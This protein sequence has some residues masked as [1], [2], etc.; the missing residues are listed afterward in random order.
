MPIIGGTR[1][2][3]GT[4]PKALSPEFLAKQG[5]KTMPAHGIHSFTVP[6]AV[7]GWAQMHKRYGKLPWK[8]LFQAAIA[9]NSTGRDA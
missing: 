8:D 1:D 7:D 2:A 9:S 4:A 5:I 6:G 3:S